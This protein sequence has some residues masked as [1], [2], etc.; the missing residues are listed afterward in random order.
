MFRSFRALLVAGHATAADRRFRV[1]APVNG[2]VVRASTVLL[3][4]TVP[5]QTSVLHQ[6][7]GKP[8]S[9]PDKVVPGDDEDL[10][11][12]RVPLQEGR[13]VIRV[14]HAADEAELGILSLT[15]IPPHSMR[16]ATSPGDRPYAFHTRAREDTCSGCHSLPEVFETVPDQ[17]LAPAAKVCGACHPRVE[18]APNLHGPVAVYSCFQC[19]EPEYTPSRFAQKTSQPASCGGCHEG[20]LARVLGG[21]KFVH[22]PAAAGACIVCHDPHGGKTTALLRETPPALCLLCHSETLPLPVERNLHGKVPCTRCHDPHGGQT[23]VFTAAAG[24]PFC[25]TCHANFSESSAAHPLEGHPVAAD[26]DPSRPGRPMGCESCHQAHDPNDVSRR[27]ISTDEAAAKK[28]CRKC[29][30]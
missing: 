29:H 5:P 24:N 26:V 22:G 16:T 27:N 13:Q 21:K 30:Y 7:D 17:P 6:A 12:V 23:R 4:Y 10:H 3:V 1:L 2:A 25:D 9:F 11:H 15:Y 14:L 28:F 8:T 20:F 18:S 19:H